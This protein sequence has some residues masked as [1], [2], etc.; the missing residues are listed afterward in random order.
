MPRPPA[1]ARV[2][3][4]VTATSREHEMFL[5]GQT[6]L[7]ACSGGPDSTCLLYSLY[8][9][10]RLLR[11]KLEVFHFDHG[12]RKDSAKDAG[13][14]KRL[15]T[16]LKLP[17]HLRTAES[18]PPK[19]SSVELWARSH[20]R[21]AMALAGRDAGAG[22]IAVGHT[23]DDQAETVLMALV[24][25]WG[26]SGL[27]G[28][29][30]V[31]GMEVRPMLDVTRKEVEAFCR[32]LR[33]RPREDPTNR[34]VRHLRNA[35]RL[36]GIPALERAT[37]R[38]LKRTFA[39]TADILRI[40]NEELWRQSLQAAE[41]LVEETPEGCLIAVRDL[42]SLPHAIRARVV[43]RAFQIGGIGWTEE[44]I[45]AVL[46]LA[47]GRP[48]RRRHLILGSTALRDEEYVRLSRTSPESRPGRRGSRGEPDRT[49]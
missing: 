41:E 28:I 29:R 7:V 24:L 34:D 27:G 33:L 39:R 25:G 19:G 10:R 49:V 1:V 20:R 30:P 8:H 9:L 26:L 4:R 47:A 21:V 18:S 46:D 32:S 48:G 6:V 2:L 38:E 15:A 16:R 5:P 45:A 31:L 43:R 23:L 22:R 13:Y 42:L 17:F 44:S 14:V 12:L 11:V 40:D 35:I 3:E 36:K 37:G